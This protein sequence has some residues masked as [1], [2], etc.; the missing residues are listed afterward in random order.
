M[1]DWLAEVADHTEVFATWR[2]TRLTTRISFTE[3]NLGIAVLNG[4]PS[5]AAMIPR[6]YLA[7][8]LLPPIWHELQHD[9]FEDEPS[10]VWLDFGVN[11]SEVRAAAGRLRERLQQYLLRVG[12]RHSPAG[13]EGFRG[14]QWR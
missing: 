8:E 6:V 7:A 14:R 2:K 11:E 12:L 4:H 9:V 5:G 10:K 13:S 3:P 1:I